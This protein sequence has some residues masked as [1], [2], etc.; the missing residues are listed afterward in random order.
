MKL[1]AHMA[2]KGPNHLLSFEEILVELEKLGA[3]VD[4]FRKLKL[5]GERPEILEKNL[6]KLLEKTI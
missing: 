2:L 5:R 6:L 3:D 1:T 4:Q